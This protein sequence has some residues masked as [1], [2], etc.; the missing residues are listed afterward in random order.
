MRLSILIGLLTCISCRTAIAQ[1]FIQSRTGTFSASISDASG[2]SWV[3]VDGDHD[4]DL[5]V[6]NR[7]TGNFLYLNDNGDFTPGSAGV[8]TSSGSIGSC[9]ADFDNDGD[10]DA[11]LAGTPG[12][13]L[14][15][16]GDGGFEDVTARLVPAGT[17]FRSWACSWADIDLDGYVD[18]LMTHPAGFVGSPSLPNFL[19]HNLGDGMFERIT[20]DPVVIGTNTYTVGTWTDFDGD[21]DPDL[22]IGMGPADGSTQPDNVYVNRFME[23][24]TA[25]FEQAE[26][27]PLDRQADGQ[28]WNWIDYDNDGD[29]DAF[30]TNFYG[31]FNT[32]MRDD[33]FRNDDGSL[34]VV[35]SGA[36]VSESG[37]SLGQMWADFDNDT[38]LDVI[39]I[40][41]GFPNGASNRYF[42]NDGAGDFTVSAVG[43]VTRS[44]G[45]AAADF[46]ND[47]DMD[48]FLPTLY[49][50]G[51]TP[52]NYLYE[53]TLDN[54]NHWL[55]IEL[56]GDM[57]NRT[58]I[59]AYVVVES[60]L[61]G[62]TPVRQR[63]DVS[64]QNTFNGMND[65]TVHFGLADDDLV[66]RIRVFW[67]SGITD[68]LTEVAA[69]QT[70]RIVEGSTSIAR[71]GVPEAPEMPGDVRIWPNP[72]ADRLSV[73]F[74]SSG[75]GP[76]RV[77]ILDVT[78]R[79]R[80]VESAGAGPG[81]GRFEI[82]IDSLPP[83]VYV[84]RLDMD[85]AHVD[86]SFVVV[87]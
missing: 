1:T 39:V 48:F 65:P 6:S 50:D 58:G 42:R 53:N 71:E 29:L 34:A 25:D 74:T 78:G 85:G 44:W 49:G 87:R 19:F 41:D 83:G 77:R 54:G 84:A 3:D 9:W 69:D 21:G 51:S 8:L 10:I 75:A 4:P 86:R 24:G 23:T 15:N 43:P 57:S 55:K 27:I 36:I 73:A 16:T 2:M 35:T 14:M 33:L 22:F 45:G 52:P 76:V 79:V 60:L 37:F 80:R 26:I 67:P 20:S 81:D 7:D 12:H 46:D 68:E 5:F 63:R 61:G 30:R 31:G 70:L 59:G 38:D 72:A 40:R 17:D 13:L 82:A 18:L 56:E 64:S 28:V 66:D 32:G 62:E 11:A 47:G